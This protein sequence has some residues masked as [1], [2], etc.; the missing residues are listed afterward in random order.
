MSLSGR[1][2]HR[3]FLS[4]QEASRLV[5]QAQDRPLT[6]GERWRLKAHLAACA[7]CARYDQQLA[8]LRATMRRYRE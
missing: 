8:F 1:I 3:L 2:F 5:S 7:A 4:C 6:G